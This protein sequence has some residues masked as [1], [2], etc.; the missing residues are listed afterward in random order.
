MAR[1]SIPPAGQSLPGNP[2][3]PD[4]ADA[5]SKNTGTSGREKNEASEERFCPSKVYEPGEED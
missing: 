2:V 4:K 5:W 1:P 3:E